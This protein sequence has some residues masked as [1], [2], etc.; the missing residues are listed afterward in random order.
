MSTET[1]EPKISIETRTCVCGQGWVCLS[2]SEDRI[3]A[4]CCLILFVT[5]DRW[6]AR[7]RGA[8]YPQ[9]ASEDPQ[10]ARGWLGRWLG[11]MF[12]KEQP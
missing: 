2:D 3:C 9:V 1:P 7:E 6:R 5:R 8:A 4:A 12:G 10:V 11:R